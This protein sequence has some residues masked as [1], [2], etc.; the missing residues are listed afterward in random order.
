M[1]M[2]PIEHKFRGEVPEAHR[3]SLDTRIAWLW[4]QRWGTVQ[5]VWQ[6]SPDLLDHTAATMFLQAVM[7]SDLDS[8]RQIFNRLEGGSLPDDT[9]LEREEEQIRV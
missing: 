2:V 6:K 1:S 7:A 8:T 9:L 4:N 5:T 3:S